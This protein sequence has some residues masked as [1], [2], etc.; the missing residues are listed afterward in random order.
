LAFRF[1]QVST[2][3][4]YGSLGPEGHFSETS[5]YA[6]TSPYSASK[7]AGDHFARAW[8]RTYR[9][10]VLITNCSNNYG[11]YQHPEKFIPTVIHNALL[12]TLVPVYGQGTNRRD[13]IHVEDHVAG[14]FAVLGRGRPG[15]S[16][17]FGGRNELSN[18]E[19]ARMVCGLID[20]RRPRRDG[21]S[22]AEQIAF[23]SDR[24]G[25]DFRY[26]IDPTK[27]E[28]E[29]GWR[30]GSTLAEGLAAT[31]DWFL[32]HADWLETKGKGLRRLGLD[33]AK[34]NESSP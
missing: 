6:P 25:H 8:H 12:G 4:V 27:A 34:A 23:V 11:P 15:E 10:P 18:L 14:I 33:R 17:N 5:P 7:A 1:I 32:S 30:A 28:A 22:C 20:E 24:P 9:L 19:L 2:D 26:A 13:W 3:E 29:L 21:R 16:Y 31:I